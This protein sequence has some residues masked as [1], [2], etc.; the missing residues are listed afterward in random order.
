MCCVGRLNAVIFVTQ[1]NGSPDKDQIVPICKMMCHKLPMLV[2]L[3]KAGAFDKDIVS[4]EVSV[5]T[6]QRRSLPID[7]MLRQCMT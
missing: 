2:C 3:N 7:C 4:E 1:W 5:L 6:R